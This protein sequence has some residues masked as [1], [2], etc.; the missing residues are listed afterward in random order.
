M[1]IGPPDLFAPHKFYLTV[2][3]FDQDV[4]GA[5]PQPFCFPSLHSL[6]I[7]L[8]SRFNTGTFL[9]DLAGPQ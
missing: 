2:L 3:L 1:H 5:V 4:L 7:V 6:S 8:S 9:I